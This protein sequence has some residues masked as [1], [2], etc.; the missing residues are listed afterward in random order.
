MPTTVSWIASWASGA[1]RAVC[2]SFNDDV[3]VTVI[4]CARAYQNYNRA[5]MKAVPRISKHVRNLALLLLALLLP[6][7]TTAAQESAKTLDWGDHAK[8][9]CGKP[10]A[11][12]S[13]VFEIELEDILIEGT[14]VLI[15]E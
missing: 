4:L 9:T 10:G 3:V 1:G 6:L 13:R 12:E 14:T 7:M 5:K 11:A 15:A 2:D 8:I